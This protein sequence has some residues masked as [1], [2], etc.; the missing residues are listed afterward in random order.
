MTTLVNSTEGTLDIELIQRDASTQTRMTIDSDIVDRYSEAMRE[1]EEFDP[2]TVFT[3]G[4]D[5]YWLADGW[6]RLHAAEQAG[7]EEIDVIVMQGE[8]RDA[9]WFALRA[10]VRH[11]KQLSSADKRRAVEIALADEEWSKL[12]DR[13]IA[14]QCGC[15]HSTVQNIRHE[16]DG[17]GEIR[18][19]KKSSKVAKSATSDHRPNDE[20]EDEAVAD[21]VEEEAEDLT[22]PDTTLQEYANPY[23][24]CLKQITSI[25]TTMVAISNDEVVGG[26]LAQ[27]VTRISSLC[28]ELRG[29]IR[30]STPSKWCK[31]GEC[32]GCV[33]CKNTMFLTLGQ[34]ESDKRK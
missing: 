11:G 20:S 14:A 13:K 19:E 8:K 26:H 29:A 25:K 23:N 22:S 17:S 7:F 9:I 18:H 10:N 34:V 2:I 33:K 6:H 21:V 5:N 30:L 32:H 15:H 3:D 4:G 28:E 24:E 31:D 27:K 1:G 12:S 16:Q